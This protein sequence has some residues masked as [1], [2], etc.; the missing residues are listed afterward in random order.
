MLFRSTI[1]VL[2][3]LSAAIPSFTG[4]PPNGLTVSAV[5]FE[6]DEHTAVDRQA[7]EDEIA[8]A[9]ETA[10]EDNADLVVF[11][12][13]IN[14]FAALSDD[15]Q[16]IEAFA[17]MDFSAENLQAD[18]RGRAA[19]G[20]ESGSGG[21]SGDNLVRALLA[22]VYRH[23]GHRSLRSLFAARAEGV[24]RW[25][26]EAYGEAAE[27]HDL[28]IVA[29]TYFAFEENGSRARL[30]NR[31]VVYAPDGTRSYE[32]DK[33]YLTAFERDLL[34]LDAAEV[35]D[36]SGFA[37]DGWSVALTICRD[38]YFD[39]WNDHHAD[40]DLWID[41]R[42]E[43]TEYTADVRRR[44]EDA[45][46]ERISETDVPYGLTVFL[47]GEFH[48]LY[49]EGRSAFVEESDDSVQPIS[50]ADASAEHDIISTT[51]GR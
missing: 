44:L 18:G 37:V 38:T 48:G 3:L 40:R 34:N 20:G 1:G 43:G 49:W 47:A 29:G 9:V 22:S 30:T 36:A 12:E 8:S 19:D 21:G 32:Q 31:A 5:Q 13:Y 42:G 10:A 27:R 28:H 6:M 11:P 15:E 17:G 16:L 7:L 50:Q 2:I 4:E 23:T 41:L 25:M 33:V 39:P 51:L 45:V 35:E 14:V 46:P 24:S 26:D